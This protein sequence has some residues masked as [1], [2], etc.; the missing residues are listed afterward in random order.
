MI[1]QTCHLDRSGAEYASFLGLIALMLCIISGHDFS[2][3][4]K[5]GD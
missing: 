5:M 2:R 4:V 3:A 1:K